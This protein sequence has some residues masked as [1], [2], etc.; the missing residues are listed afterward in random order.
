MKK[1]YD[2]WMQFEMDFAEAKERFIKHGECRHLEQ[3]LEVVNPYNCNIKIIQC[4]VC[5]KQIERMYL[6]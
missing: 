5:N 3:F 4:S 1:N 2:Q 6:G